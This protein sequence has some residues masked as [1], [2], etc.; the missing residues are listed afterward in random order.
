M[1]R[2]ILQS[3]GLPLRAFGREVVVVLVDKILEAKRTDPS[4]DVSAWERE[5]GI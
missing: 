1:R 5:I 3:C 4:A 2:A